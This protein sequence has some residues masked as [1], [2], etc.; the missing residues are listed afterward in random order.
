MV[1]ATFVAGAA[2]LALD[3][4]IH[5]GDECSAVGGGGREA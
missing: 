1:Y 5:K 3:G 4:C 2:S